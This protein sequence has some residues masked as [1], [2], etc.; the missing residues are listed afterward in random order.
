[1]GETMVHL[2]ASTMAELWVAFDQI[3]A[4]RSSD[5]VVSWMFRIED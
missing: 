3:V 4:W 2:V 5:C 1:M